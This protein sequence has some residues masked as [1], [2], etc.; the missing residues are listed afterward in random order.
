MK[1][2]FTDICL[3]TKDVPRLRA[4]YETVF[5]GTSGGDEFHAGLSVGGTGFTFAHVDTLREN[6]PFRFVTADAAQNI[7]MSFDVEDVDAEHQRLLQ[8]GVHMLNAPITHPWGT[9]SFQ[10]MD[11]DGNILNFRSVENS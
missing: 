9:R 11:P 3:V 2:T 4:F 8:L 1:I 5:G 10:F 6:T 7:I